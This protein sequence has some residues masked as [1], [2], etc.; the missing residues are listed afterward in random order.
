MLQLSIFDISIKKYIWTRLFP[1]EI[2]V[3]LSGKEYFENFQE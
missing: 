1:L 2:V 3:I